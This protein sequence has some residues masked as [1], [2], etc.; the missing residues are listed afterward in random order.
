MCA[1]ASRGS[2]A[3]DYKHA[4]IQFKYSTVKLLYF[5]C[6]L[7]L[8]FLE[9]ITLFLSVQWRTCFLYNN[10][11]PKEVELLST[12]KQGKIDKT[13]KRQVYFLTLT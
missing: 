12:L 9:C 6:F 1:A 5:K 3:G 7:L 2:A 13:E 10:S 4:S 11:G 8:K